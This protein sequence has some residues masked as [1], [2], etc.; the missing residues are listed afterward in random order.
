VI[1]A[2]FCDIGGPIYSDENY[3]GA[4]VAALDSLRADGG[5]PP[6]D[7][8][9]IRAVYDMVRERQGGSLRTELA[10]RFLRGPSSRGELSERTREYWTH[11]AGT[12]SP[13]VIPFLRE[14]AHRR[15]RVVIGVLANQ[16]QGVVDAMKR[17]GV[18][19]YVDIWGV[20]ALVGYEKPSRELF[21]WCLDRAGVPPTAAVHIG[22]RLDMDVRP[23]KSV[24]MKTVWLL[25]GEAPSSPTKAQLAEAD[26][27]AHS[28]DGLVPRLFG[29]R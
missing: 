14:L 15:P 17:D 7:V 25:R 12:L 26:M 23:A 28:L 8:A 24:G 9:E 22:N 18:S 21:S 6:V 29:D 4:V 11:P 13:D 5:W 1:S 10:S 3:F 27:V 16:E 2:V 20:S 19:E